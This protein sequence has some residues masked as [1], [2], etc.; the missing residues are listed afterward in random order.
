M[1]LR[2]NINISATDPAASL[3]GGLNKIAIVSPQL[4]LTITADFITSVSFSSGG[5]NTLTSELKCP[6]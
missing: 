2:K 4:K 3:S 6:H 1:T 5:E